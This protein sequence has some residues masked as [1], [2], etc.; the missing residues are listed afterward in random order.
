MKPDVKTVWC[1]ALRSKKYKQGKR[2]LRK[3]NRYCCLGVLTDLYLKAHN[4]KWSKSKEKDVYSFSC[5]SFSLPEPVCKWADLGAF[6]YAGMES[7]MALNDG[8]SFAPEKGTK[9]FSEI[10][11]LIETKL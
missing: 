3:K 9:T 2:Y 7:L 5:T 4:L 11:D 8:D 6:P 10:A 1:A